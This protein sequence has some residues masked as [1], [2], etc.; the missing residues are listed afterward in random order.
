[1]V[2][3]EAL[4]HSPPWCPSAYFSPGKSYFA[5]LRRSLT[6]SNEKVQCERKPWITVAFRDVSAILEP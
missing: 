5:L 4:E 1:M 3:Y 2:L 6:L